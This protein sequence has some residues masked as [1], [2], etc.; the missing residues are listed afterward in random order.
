MIKVRFYS[1]YRDVLGKNEIVITNQEMTVKEILNHISDNYT[2]EFRKLAIQND[3]ISE[4]MFVIV[5]DKH[6]TTIDHIVKDGQTV[7]LMTAA[8]G[9]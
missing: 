9:G 4:H 7:K 5:E 3:K 2:E 6:V 8:H 1:E